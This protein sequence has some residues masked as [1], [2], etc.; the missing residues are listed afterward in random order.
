[1]LD[2][3]RVGQGSQQILNSC[4]KDV[5]LFNDDSRDVIS[6]QP[7]LSSPGSMW[8]RPGERAETHQ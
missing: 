5:N 3:P 8:N 4:Y 1:M 2:A 6:S 7:L